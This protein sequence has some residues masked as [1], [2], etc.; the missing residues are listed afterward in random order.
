MRVLM[1]SLT[2]LMSCRSF[3]GCCDHIDYQTGDFV[4]P[5]VRRGGRFTKRPYRYVCRCGA[6]SA[7][8]CPLP[9]LYSI[10]AIAWIGCGS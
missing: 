10:A 2:P 4:V 6:G 5:R 7:I 3:L 1:W 9:F 8:S